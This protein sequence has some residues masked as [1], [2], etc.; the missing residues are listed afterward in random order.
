MFLLAGLHH[1][2]LNI[3][4]D[5]SCCH[6]NFESFEHLTSTNETIMCKA[7]Q[8]IVSISNVVNWF[9]PST[10]STLH[11]DNLFISKIW[12][13]LSWDPMPL[14]S[15]EKKRIKIVLFD[16]IVYTKKKKKK[17][18]C[19]VVEVTGHLQLCVWRGGWRKFLKS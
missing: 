2:Y 17:K 18:R 13:D 5:K 10:A 11:C 8:S 4:K 6:L 16:N 3:L 7:L 14:K 15:D 1:I 9:P 19:D 12:F